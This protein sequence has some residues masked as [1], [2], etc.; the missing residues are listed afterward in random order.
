[1][2]T[3]RHVTGDGKAEISARA[4]RSRA[5]GGGSIQARLFQVS[6]RQTAAGRTDGQGIWEL[7]NDPHGP[8]SPILFLPLGGPVLSIISRDHGTGSGEA[9]L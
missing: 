6:E 4:G 1:M 9:E 8:N 2:L 5:G 7:R 3:K